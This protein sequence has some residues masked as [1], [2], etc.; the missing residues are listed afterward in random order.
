MFF[1]VLFYRQIIFG[2]NT[3]TRKAKE[4]MNPKLEIQE[5]EPRNSITRIWTQ[6]FK[7]ISSSS[8]WISTQNFDPIKSTQNPSK[9][10]IQDQNLR[11][12][13]LTK[14]KKKM[15]QRRLG[16]VNSIH[17]YPIFWIHLWESLG[18]WKGM[19]EI[20]LWERRLRFHSR[21]L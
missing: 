10:S 6:N 5:H 15:F 2:I 12:R 13:I 3:R 19:M 9:R 1:I 11:A 21:K 7:Q 8:S 14:S 17:S 4:K 18:E 20:H 16:S